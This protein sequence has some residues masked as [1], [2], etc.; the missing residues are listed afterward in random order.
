MIP[1]PLPENDVERVA[2]LAKMRLLST[3]READLDRITRVAKRVFSTEIA[4]ISLVDRDRQWFKARLGLDASE[5]PRDISF[6]GHTIEE[7]RTFVVNNALEDERFHDNPLVVGETNIRF[8]AG[9]PL[10]N[11]EGYR[12]GTLCVISPKPRDFSEGDQQILKDLARMVETVL[13]NRILSQTQAALLDSLTTA[14]RDKL[15]DPLTSIWNRRGFDEL[16]EREVARARRGKA[17]IAIAMVDIDAFKKINDT[18]GHSV[19]D[20][21]IKLAASLLVECSRATD[22]VVRYGGEE[23]LVIAPDT[24]RKTLAVL[25][26]KILMAFRQYAKL[27]VPADTYPFTVSIGLASASPTENASLFTRQLLVAAD[28]ALYIAKEAGRDRI[29]I[30][31]KI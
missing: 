16:I 5:T 14:T 19:G 11:N 12:I 1:A 2:S 6:C 20:E 13:E 7:D 27:Q 17:S 30:S 22:I 23:F 4:L 21:A 28:E 15:I 10:T 18:F 8:Y 3:P 9:Q 24:P 25:G 29:K 26:D 31:D